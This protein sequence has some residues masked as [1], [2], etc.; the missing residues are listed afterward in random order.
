LAY[1]AF[2][3]DSWVAI[4]VFWGYFI[5]ISAISFAI[6][7]LPFKTW[8]R[9]VF[10][11]GVRPIALKM[12]SLAKTPYSSTESEIFQMY[13]CFCIKYIFPWAIWWLLVM[14]TAKDIEIPYEGYNVGWQVIGLLIPIFGLLLFLLPLIFFKGK[15]DSAFKNAFKITDEVIVSKTFEADVEI[16]NTVPVVED[17][18]AAPIS[19]KR[20]IDTVVVE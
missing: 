7:R 3:Q 11:S 10:F 16:I 19:P 15:T 1:F 6:S 8:Y 20:E 2:P 12:M 4:P 13:W 5:I 18:G 14:T 9:E 17:A